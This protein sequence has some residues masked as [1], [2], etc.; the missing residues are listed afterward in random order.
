MN[1]HGESMAEAFDHVAALVEIK[2][3]AETATAAVA[4]SAAEAR[5]AGAT[6]EAKAAE[7]RAAAAAAEAKAAEARAAEAAEAAAEVAAAAE[8]RAAEAAEAAAEVAEAAAAAEAR[9]AA[10]SQA[11]VRARRALDVMTLS[12]RAPDEDS[13][14]DRAFALPEVWALV[15][16]HLG[17]VRAWQLMRVCKTARAGVREFLRTLPGLV[18]CGGMADGGLGV[19]NEVWRLDLATMR[20]GAMPALV[21]A[22]YFH[23]CCTVRGKPVVFGGTGSVLGCFSSVEMLSSEEGGFVELPPLS[24]GG[25]EGAVAIAADESE[26]ALGQVILL[27][28]A[29]MPRFDLPLSTVHLVDLATGVC[30]SKPDM[31]G[32]RRLCDFAADGLPG[33]RIVCA[34]GYNVSSAEIWG[35]PVQGAPGAAWTWRH[36]PAMSAARIGCCGCVMSDGRFAVIGGYY[37]SGVTSSACEALTISDDEEHW[38]PLLPMHD[39]RHHS[40]CVTR[41]GKSKPKQLTPFPLQES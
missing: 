17:L 38:Q 37:D 15:A 22:R 16:L 23:A 14:V 35:P 34:G 10:A 7:Q 31:L 29:Q 27:G 26:S 13:A 11:V 9:V 36:L 28:G 41:E 2:V 39:A 25:I 24:C 19:R 8:A 21:T 30:T 12:T 40:A 3:E 5:A 6:A 33:G 20:W 1:A 18:V 32:A 4:A